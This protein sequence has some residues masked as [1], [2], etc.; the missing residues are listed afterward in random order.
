MLWLVWGYKYA[1][2]SSLL[3]TYFLQARLKKVELLLFEVFQLGR[4]ISGRE[5]ASSQPAASA[6]LEL[7]PVEGPEPSALSSPGS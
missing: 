1:S 6:A 4:V 7:F 5:C 3:C 2:F